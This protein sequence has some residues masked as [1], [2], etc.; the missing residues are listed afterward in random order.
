MAIL[1]GIGVRWYKTSQRAANET[2][3]VANL[4]LISNAQS[5][6]F[7]ISNHSGYGTFAQLSSAG[8]LGKEFAGNTPAVDGYIYK[9]ALTPR[10]STQAP[11][12]AV[13]ADPQK[14]TGIMATGNRFF[15]TSS[16]S[17]IITTNNEKPAGPDDPLVGGG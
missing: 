2:S 13:N 5:I 4:Q 17:N 8:V 1:I 7:K 14:L 12:F 3:A 15:Y 16:G 10:S 11:G 6:Y 9:M